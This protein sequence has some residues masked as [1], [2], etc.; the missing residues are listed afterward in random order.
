MWLQ[1]LDIFGVHKDTANHLG[2]PSSPNPDS[3]DLKSKEGSQ[4]RKSRLSWFKSKNADEG[5]DEDDK[6]GQNKEFKQALA[7]QSPES[8]RTAFWS[9]V[10][11]DDPDALLLRFLRARKW[12]VHEALV[13][14]ISTMHWRGQEMHVD[15]E[16]MFKGEPGYLKQSKTATG[17]EKKD[18]EDFMAILRKGLSF[19][20]GIDSENRPITIVRARA[21]HPNE[22]TDKAIEA[23]TVYV[24]ETARMLLRSPVDTATIVFDMNGFS[25]S[26]M[27]YTPVKFMIKCFEANYPESLGSVLV[28]KAPWIFQGIWKI[29]KGWLD[30][31]VASKVHFCSDESELSAY[32]P[33]SRILKELGGDE[34]W[35]YE[36]S[37]PDEG[38]DAPIQDATTR[39]KIEGERKGLVERF[40]ADTVGWAKGEGAKSAER[41]GG[42]QK[43]RENYWRLDPYIRAR[44][45][46]DRVGMIGPGDRLDFYPSRE[47][48]K[49]SHDDDV[50]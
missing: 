35:R 19:I 48:A 22:Q 1:V 4:K 13:M 34:D 10:K 43:L 32:I 36:Y 29:I 45:L 15:D 39:G 44:G 6:H 24:I 3:S 20:H 28:Y 37:D 12:D 49:T 42:K 50:D 30:P 18:A 26:N 9:M 17:S 38:R 40:E 8:L 2:V 41:E 11:H 21:H 46:C 33:K 5:A 14:M 16:L 25:M 23:Y 7:T 47:R 27:D 31:V